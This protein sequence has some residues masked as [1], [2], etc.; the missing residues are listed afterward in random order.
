MAI[1]Y[2]QLANLVITFEL[3]DMDQVLL[4]VLLETNQTDTF[5]FNMTPAYISAALSLLTTTKRSIHAKTVI[6]PDTHDMAQVNLIA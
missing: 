1:H 3:N 2:L 4:N 5:L 6:V